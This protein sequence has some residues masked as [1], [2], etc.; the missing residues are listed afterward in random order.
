MSPE[1]YH[2]QV[3]PPKAITRPLPVCML[4]MSG[5]PVPCAWASTSEESFGRP[6]RL[7]PL[8]GGKASQS[9][10]FSSAFGSSRSTKLRRPAGLGVNFRPPSGSI[11][12][13]PSR[14]WNGT[15]PARAVLPH[16]P[17]P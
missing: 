7:A 2:G 5:S 15:I 6:N 17:S 13:S 16:P 11:C 4:I 1:R 14:I 8:R 10:L 3:S 12:P 9:R